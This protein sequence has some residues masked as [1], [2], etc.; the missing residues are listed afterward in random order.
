MLNL[1]EC[2]ETNVTKIKVDFSM[3]EKY[4]GAELQAMMDEITKYFDLELS[5]C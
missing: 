1:N 4:D 3:L 5:Y 2:I